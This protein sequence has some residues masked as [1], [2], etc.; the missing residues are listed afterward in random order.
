MDY[1]IYEELIAGIPGNI[2]VADM[3]RSERRSVVVAEPGDPDVPCAQN[4]ADL[5]CTAGAVRGAPAAARAAAAAAAACS[6]SVR[7]WGAGANAGACMNFA[8]NTRPPIAAG[9]APGMSLRDLARASLSWNLAE[10]SMGVAA[11]NAYYNDLRLLAGEKGVLVET[12]APRAA[13]ARTHGGASG[14]A[15]AAAAG[16]ESAGKDKSV[17]PFEL[18][19]SAYSGKKVGVIGHFSG[20]DT[21]VAPYC[22]LSIF[23]REPRP[24]D[25]PDEAEEYLLPLMDYVFITGCTFAN[26]SLPR[27]LELSRK[28][29]VVLVGPSVPCA[30]LLFRYGVSVL[31]SLVFPRPEDAAAALESTVP[32][33]FTSYGLKISY[34]RS[35]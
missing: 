10:A 24:G 25:Y 3:L 33:S 21:D 1:T 7:T 29:F 20:L 5:S 23:E 11:I 18:Y 15:A 17:D 27:L 35:F 4:A 28:A 34:E 26:K 16:G 12:G 6:V 2:R 30:P 31:S 19:R 22:E 8:E 13:G 9:A 14:A 32:H